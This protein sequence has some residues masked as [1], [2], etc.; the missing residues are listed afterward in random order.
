MKTLRVETKMSPS[1]G[2]EAIAR[3]LPCE[4]LRPGL[5]KNG[6]CAHTCPAMTSSLPV[7]FP[8]RFD[9][10]YAGL[11]RILLLPPEESYADITEQD[12]SV[13]MGW[14][15]RTTFPRSAIASVAPQPEVPLSRGVHGLLGKWLVNGSGKGILTMTLSPAQRGY[16]LGVPVQVRELSISFEDPAVV[17]DVLKQS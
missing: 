6:G 7:R 4:E 16:V 12:V 10:L 13:R 15:F 17:A 8:I 5:L 1:H 11:S 3:G 14:A 2:V 9:R